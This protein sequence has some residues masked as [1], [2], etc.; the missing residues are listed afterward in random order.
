[1]YIENDW[2]R[3]EF[4]R[5]SRHVTLISADTGR[6][7]TSGT[8][9]VWLKNGGSQWQ[10]MLSHLAHVECHTAGETLVIV[11]MHHR[12]WQIIWR[13][14]LLRQRLGF[15]VRVDFNNQSAD[16]VHLID[17]VLWEGHYVPDVN[18]GKWW[19]L[20]NGW[21]S[22]SPSGESPGIS[23]S[24]LPHWLWLRDINLGST[25]YR[26]TWL[27]RGVVSE[28][29]GS[30]A[31]TASHR[32]LVVG[33]L[34]CQAGFGEIFLDRDKVRLT[35]QAELDI[36]AGQRWEGDW[37]V[38]FEQEKNSAL[39]S[40]AEL[41]AAKMRLPA[42]RPAKTGWCSWYWYGP[43][44]TA[45]VVSEEL[46]AMAKISAQL[47]L[48][49][50]LIDG[51][52]CRWGD[53]LEPNREKFP[54][55]LAVWGKRIRRSGFEPGLWWAPVMCR[56]NAQV[57]REH[58]DWLLRDQTGRPVEVRK[59]TASAVVDTAGGWG[60]Y[61]LDPTHPQVQDYLATVARTMVKKWG[62][63][64]LKVDFLYQACMGGVYHRSMSRLQA[65]REGLRVV[66]EAAGATAYLLGCGCPL[67]AGVGLVDAMRIGLDT[68]QPLTRRIPVLGGLINSFSYRQ[69]RR[70][71]LARS[72]MHQKW[73]N[74]DPDCILVSAGQH[75]PEVEIE[76]MV[77]LVRR[78]GGQ[79][80]VGDSL[81]ELTEERI[82]KYLRPSL[83][84]VANSSLL[85]I[86]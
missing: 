52:W 22:W 28:M 10:T 69:A 18:S 26:G 64:Y 72:F 86:R 8:A 49:V 48:R 42:V 77:E 78:V 17:L 24:H 14:K 33:K 23:S 5:E 46:A 85:T 4:D 74:N 36:L 37:G 57:V 66:R 6:R 25:R 84:E 63:S 60:T 11:G 15:E 70:N 19:V 54:Q 56:P 67:E 16:R 59:I 76:A 38:V 82:E 39:D 35:C 32:S 41:L 79:V 53:W 83:S 71:I 21:Q 20:E 65:L 80:F 40:Y 55:G 45:G 73:W 27:K 34:T 81:K 9:G 47:P 3:L 12:G 7:V 44:I 30:L 31:S 2:A 1:M 29:V 75:L 62:F 68:G 51:G 43:S 58:P 13:A 50:F 61:G